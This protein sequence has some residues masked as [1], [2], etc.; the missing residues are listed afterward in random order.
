MNKINKEDI[1][2]FQCMHAVYCPP[3][4]GEVDDYHLVKER[5]HLK[6]GTTIPNVRMIKNWKRSFWVTKKGARNHQ[7]KKERELLNR[8]ERYESTE[9]QMVTN[10]AKALEMPWFKGTMRDL[11]SNPYLYGTDI[12]STALIKGQYRE[13]FPDCFAP[14][15]VACFDTETYMD[16]GTII[17]ATLSF[18]DKVF[19]AIRKDYF[20]GYTNVENRLQEC[21]DTYL[22]K[23]KKERNINWEVQIVDDEA[24]VVVETFKRAHAWKPDFLAIWNINFDMPKVISALERAGIQPK[25]VFSDPKVPHAYRHFKYKEGKKVRVMASGKQMPINFADQW[26]VVFC[27]SSFYFIDAMCVY[28]KTRVQKGELPRYSLD[29]VLGLELGERKLRFTQADA[30]SG[31]EWHEVMQT[32]FK[33]EYVVY[34]V[35]DCVSMEMLDEKI[36]DLSIDLPSACAYSDYRSFESQPK[37][38]VDEMHYYLL[39][40]EESVIGSTGSSEFMITKVDKQAPPNTDLIVNLKASLIQDNG[41]QCIE[42]Y[43][44]LHTSFRTHNY[45]SDVSGAY[46]S[47]TIV[48]NL[49]RETCKRVMCRIQ[50]KTEYEMRMA[51]IN[52]SGG[53]TNSLELAQSMFGLPTLPDVLKIYQKDKE[54]LIEAI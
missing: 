26:H 2:G 23:Y 34:N 24:Q 32:E 13:K 52:L 40:D 12:F 53:H 30:Y 16:D 39:E 8:L 47:N 29:Y 5:I 45:D 49:A 4:Y 41:L 20:E 33:F 36:L 19:T 27:P 6:D 48:F 10:V 28:R 37:R 51:G 43:P 54:K 31:G 25:D 9:S 42:E 38:V 46:P 44:D 14:S 18:K 7:Q 35:F 15:S 11:N 17:M 21:F 1:V 3:P 22:G 50:N